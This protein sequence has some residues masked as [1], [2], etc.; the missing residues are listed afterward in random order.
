MQGDNVTNLDF[1]ELL[2]KSDADPN[3]QNHVGLTPLMCTTSTAP[4]AAKFL[5]K[6]PTMVVNSTSQSG[7]SF[8]ADVRLT[9][10]YFSEQIVRPDNPRPIFAPAVV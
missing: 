8:L 9:V 10:K 6:W 1:V 4:G 7:A 5:M 3:A 2:L